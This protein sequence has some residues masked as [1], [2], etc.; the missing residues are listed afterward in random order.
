MVAGRLANM[1]Q[2]AR[3]DIAHVCA[4]SQDQAAA[5]STSTSPIRPPCSPKSGLSNFGESSFIND[6]LREMP[7]FNM[8]RGGGLV[9]RRCANVRNVRSRALRLV[10]P[11]GRRG[12]AVSGQVRPEGQIEQRTTY[13]STSFAEATGQSE[14]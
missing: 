3:T 11:A 5:A 6:Q 12:L 4:T 7:C 8:T 14:R 13:L 10:S 9:L 1:T 2:G